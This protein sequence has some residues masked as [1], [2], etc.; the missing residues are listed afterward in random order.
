MTNDKTKIPFPATDSDPAS[1]AE[2]SGA[3]M[4]NISEYDGH[5]AL[6][7]K[8]KGSSRQLLGKVCIVA[9]FVHDIKCAWKKEEKEIMKDVLIKTVEELN[10]QSGLS[11]N[12][13]ALSYAYDDVPVQLKYER[14]NYMPLVREV[15]CQYGNYNN[16][17]GY[18]AHYKAKF[19]K[20]E[21]PIVFFLH[22]DFRSFAQQHSSESADS[23]GELSFVSY[24]DNI[25]NCVR[26]LIHELMHQFGAIDYYLPAKVKAVAEKVFDNS[27]MNGGLQID[28]LTRYLIG[29]DKDPDES[30][31]SFLEQTKDVTEE[32]IT[33]AY[34]EDSDNDW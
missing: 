7:A 21:A 13:L 11:K 17:A 30:V 31:F 15:L 29:W 33:Q 6:K 1:D 9:F 18:S 10:R 22:K 19:S 26:T 14:D 3:V 2:I 24:R 25:D 28:P 16:A 20:D 23:S 8:D 32:E 27:V 12:K 5:F 4:K 34:I